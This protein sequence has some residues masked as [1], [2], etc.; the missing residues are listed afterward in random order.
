M[1]EKLFSF[2]NISF[3]KEFTGDIGTRGKVSK[4][5]FSKPLL[6][7]TGTGNLSHSF[8]GLCRRR[9]SVIPC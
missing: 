4:E 3:S 1:K 5:V 9:N 6:P 2:K 7:L 8:L